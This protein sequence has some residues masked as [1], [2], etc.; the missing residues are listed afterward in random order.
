M[1]FGTL[2]S[3]SDITIEPADDITIDITDFSDGFIDI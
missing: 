2:L 1:E 3:M